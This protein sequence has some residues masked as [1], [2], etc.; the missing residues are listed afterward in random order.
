MK[1]FPHEY[2]VNV[3]GS[4]VG[5]L[6]V[7]AAGLPVLLGAAPVE[8]DGPGNR[9]SPETLLVAAVANCFV[10]T[11]RAV[12]GRMELPWT[13]VRCEVRG[14]VDRLERQVQFTEFTIHAHVLLLPGTSADLAHRALEKSKDGCLIT[15]SLKAASRLEIQI[16][17]VALS[18]TA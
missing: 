17:T 18:Q 1:A 16:E 8:F 7:H 10:L 6:E 3:S 13:S 4:A 12:A 11:F 15:N 9:W 14:T 5:D 2:S